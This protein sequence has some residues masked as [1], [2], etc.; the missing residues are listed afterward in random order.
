MFVHSIHYISCTHSEWGQCIIPLA[1][2]DEKAGWH[3]NVTTAMAQVMSGGVVLSMAKAEPLQEQDLEI[4][5]DDT[6]I[7]HEKCPP[8]QSKYLIYACVAILLI[9]VAIF[10]Y[11]HFMHMDDQKEE[12][13]MIPMIK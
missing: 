9:L 12:V 5:D 11:H 6:C 2:T 3:D 10:A 1:E 7:K 8:A 13:P 4:M